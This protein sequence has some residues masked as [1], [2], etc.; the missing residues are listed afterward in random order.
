MSYDLY[1]LQR[2]PGEDP[3]ETA[4]AQLDSESEE[5]NPGPLDPA[6]E[7]RKEMLSRALMNANSSLERFQ[8]GYAEIAASGGISEEEARIRYRHVELNGPE[9]GNGIQISLH[10]DH[11][12]ITI[13]FWHQP[14]AAN[15][16]FDEIWRYLRVLQETGGFFI[17][18]PQLDCVIDLDTD[19]EA[20]INEYSGVVAKIP[21]MIERAESQ[22]QRPWWKLW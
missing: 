8:F 10:D 4:A 7:A 13:P 1:L 22:T 20:V 18:D 3:L 15:Q 12:S 11:A 14:P 9:D 16:A 17:Y 19:R 21:Q 2:V 6:A 5:I